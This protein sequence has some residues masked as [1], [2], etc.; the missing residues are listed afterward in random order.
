M[1]LGIGVLVVTKLFVLLGGI[2]L[3]SVVSKLFV[4]LVGITLSS[5]SITI[6]LFLGSFSPFVSIVIFSDL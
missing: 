2:T 1:Y 6:F 3:F 5:V 4:F